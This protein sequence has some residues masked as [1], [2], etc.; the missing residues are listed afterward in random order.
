MRRL[1]LALIDLYPPYLGAG[2][3]VSRPDAASFRVRMKLRWWNANYV[4]T[5]FGG[6]LYSMC[7]P[8]FM[9]LLLEGLGKEY[10]VWDKEAT[11]R[12]LRP[13]HGKVEARFHIPA[14]RLEKIRQ[15]ADRAGKVEP[16]FTVEVTDEQGET[17]AQVDKRLY[18]RR[19][20]TRPD[21]AD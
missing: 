17:V 12:F 16:E 4:G 14:E 9:L 6:S 2:I 10:V 7:D 11:I 8:F 18:V 5:H 13:G 20:E 19:K 15:A 21:E 1:R 3:R